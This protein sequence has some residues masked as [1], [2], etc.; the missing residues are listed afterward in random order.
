MPREG[1]TGTIIEVIKES[2]A[3]HHHLKETLNTPLTNIH[4]LRGVRIAILIVN[5]HHHIQ[6]GLLC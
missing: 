1:E 4:V 3:L 6:E 5:L 2:Q